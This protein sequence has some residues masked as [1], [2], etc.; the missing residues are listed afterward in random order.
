MDVGAGGPA[1]GALMSKPFYS[2]DGTL[3]VEDLQADHA[4]VE[5]LLNGTWK[6]TFWAQQFMPW[7]LFNR[8]PQLK[9]ELRRRR[10]P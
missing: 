6:P 9:A 3:L 5:T 1:A 8:Y 2:S 7:D 10:A 4:V